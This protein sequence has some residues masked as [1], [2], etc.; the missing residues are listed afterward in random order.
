MS[1]R[2]GVAAKILGSGPGT[3]AVPFPP[4]LVYA[5]GLLGAERGEEH[6][7]M[8]P[9]TGG[10]VS[11]RPSCLGQHAL[12][13]R[14]TRTAVGILVPRAPPE[15]KKKKIDAASERGVSSPSM[16]LALFF[17]YGA[18][19]MR[20]SGVRGIRGALS[21]LV[22]ILL[23]SVAYAGSG[24]APGDA[25]CDQGNSIACGTNL[26]KKCLQSDPTK[27]CTDVVQGCKCR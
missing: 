8:Q 17:S 7:G 2:Q 25:N 21:S 5:E 16:A 10:P 27:I 1:R 12:H 4:P 18:S 20:T 6:H 13:P 22:V 15:S 14:E 24:L 26:G 3:A 19:E 11:S 23:A 9:L